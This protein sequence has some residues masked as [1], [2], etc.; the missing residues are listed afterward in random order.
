MAERHFVSSSELKPKLTGRALS[1]AS[2]M[3]VNN[4]IPMR[5]DRHGRFYYK[6]RIDRFSWGRYL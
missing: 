6:S 4:L 5:R 3:T 2:P 1:G